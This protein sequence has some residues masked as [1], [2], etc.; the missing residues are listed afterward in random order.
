MQQLP[1]PWITPER[2]RE[3]ERERATACLGVL[4]YGRKAGLD[5]GPLISYK[6]QWLMVLMDCRPLI[7]DGVG[8]ADL[9]AQVSGK[10][11]DCLV[12]FNEWSL[13]CTILV[14]G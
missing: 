9:R 4:C 10:F 12:W 11:Q 2:Q 14:M 8:V 1:T 7:H 3:R 13:F 5:Y 6:F